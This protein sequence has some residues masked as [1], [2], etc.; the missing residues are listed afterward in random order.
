MNHSPSRFGSFRLALPTLITCLLPLVLFAQDPNVRYV[1]SAGRDANDGSVAAPF[2]TI[3]HAIDSAV[4]GGTVIVLEGR[5]A[6]PGNVSLNFQGKAITLQSR[7]PADPVCVSETILDAEGSGVIARFINGEGA[8][9]V[10]DGFT[11]R[12]GDRT[13]FVRGLPGYFEISGN[14]RPTTRNLRIE[15]SPS[16]AKPPKADQRSAAY[17]GTPTGGR[18]WD[19]NNPFLQPA[20]TTN[21]YG[22][23]DVNGDG[24]VSSADVILVQRMAAGSDP[25]LSTADVD[26]NGVVDSA[27]VALITGALSGGTLPAWWNRLTTVAQR[28]AWV[29][30][31]MAR[32]QTNR[33]IYDY[34]FACGSFALQ[35]HIHG[36]FYRNDLFISNS[37][38]GGQT[39]FNVPLYVAPVASTTF[40]HVI[41]AILVGDD[42]RKLTDWRFVEPQ[43]DQDVRPGMWNMPYGTEVS[44]GVPNNVLN[45]AFWMDENK[46]VFTIGND[47]SW[48]FKSKSPSLVLTR[49]EPPYIAVDNRPDLWNPRILPVGDGMLLLD[50]QRADMSRV[51]DIHL[52]DL[53]FADP[54]SAKP[55]VL[56]SQ[57]SRLLD[58]AKAPDGTI[59]LLWAGGA[60]YNPG[61]FYGVLDTLTRSLKNVT[62][63]TPLTREV[64]SG[65]LA[66]TASGEVHAF[67]FALRANIA[68][69]YQSGVF[70]SKWT[71]SQWTTEQNVG[72]SGAFFEWAD[73]HTVDASRY[74]FDV[75]IAG[76][77]SILLVW[78][79][80]IASN[81]NIVLMQRRYTGGSWSQPSQIEVSSQ[82][83]GGVDLAT[84]S[85]GTVHLAYWSGEFPNPIGDYSDG[86]LFHRKFVGS[87]WSSP[88]TIDGGGRASCPRLVRGPNSAIY[89]V[90]QRNTASQI[91]PVW[92]R[93]SNSAWGTEHVLSVN[94][95]ADA[96]YPSADMLADGRLAIAWSSRSADRVGIQTA[97]VNDSLNSLTIGGKI[98]DSH[99]L[100]VSG[101]AI[102][103][104]GSQNYLDYDR[105]CG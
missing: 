77:G 6:G 36:A 65:R 12:P 94:A 19:G 26:G 25:F 56:D 38:G 34:W 43:T 62:R 71:G 92:R 64:H 23:G 49:P 85:A 67:W 42:P 79:D 55:L 39:L 70:W 97:Y 61:V 69:S 41:N 88:E 45:G 82:Y 100:A 15:G 37:F 78:W 3:Q 81:S 59:Y 46:V 14:A 30:K 52:T 90:W 40:G 33:H 7:K 17:S 103:L 16:L 35:T 104:T 98:S 1:S 95:G 73:W 89:V 2:R 58:V 54:P 84:D 66:V 11:L 27:D 63:I 105:C 75:A 91:V 53:P 87:S 51:D 8:G 21:Y 32:E 60:D 18:A 24:T 99:G 44:I 28:N 68:G 80:R 102:T 47:G 22:S 29:D 86:N 10:F 57:H 76:D 4:P 72:P 96:Y 5:Y 83:H 9:A 48:S 13:A 74:L 93:Y 20:P 50:R 101:V 31:V